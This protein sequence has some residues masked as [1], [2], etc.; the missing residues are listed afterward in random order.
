MKIINRKKFIRSIIIS[1]FL[2][3]FIITT[4]SNITLSH[5]ELQFKKRIVDS[6]ETLWAIAREEQNINSYYTNKDIRE[7]ISD[8]RKI[9]NLTSSNLK[10]GQELEIPTI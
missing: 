10:I 6:G 5:N 8:I 3:F 7:I 2:M 1:A 4:T 9:N